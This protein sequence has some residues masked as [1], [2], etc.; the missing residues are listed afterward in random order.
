MAMPIPR[1]R[2]VKP[3]QT[4]IMKHETRRRTLLSV[5][6]AYGYFENLRASLCTEVKDECMKFGDGAGWRVNDK[7]EAS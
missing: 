5:D 2:H 7:N 3:G 6:G 1:L 4:I